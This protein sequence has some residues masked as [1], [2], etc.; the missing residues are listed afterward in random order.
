M[1]LQEHFSILQAAHP[2]VFFGKDW[3]CGGNVG[4]GFS[5]GKQVEIFG[6]RQPKS[7]AFENREDRGSLS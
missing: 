3:N 4:R 2:F 1:F 7:P 6:G 5:A